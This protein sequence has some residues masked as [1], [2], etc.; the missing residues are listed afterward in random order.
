MRSLIAAGILMLSPVLAAASQAP[1][2]VQ[3]SSG[4]SCTALS[5][6]FLGNLKKG[7]FTAAT[8]HFDSKMQSAL[9]PQRLQQAWQESLPQ[10]F[11]AFKH[12]AAP[13]TT[14]QGAHTRVVTPLEF[15]DSW[16]SMIVSCNK[17]G[18]IEG[19]FFRPSSAPSRS[20][21]SAS[22]WI[23]AV[24]VGAKTL[25]ITVRRH[26]F[27]LKGVLDLP[28][29]KGPFPVID[30]IPGSGPVNLNGNDHAG[31]GG[32]ITYSPYKKLAAAVVK[33]GWAV[34]R[35]AKRGL[36]PSAG[37]GS[38]VVFANQVADNLA[39]VEALRKNPRVDPHRIVVAGHSIGGLVAL[40]LAVKTSVAGLILL[41]AP[42]ESMKKITTAQVL[43]M[44]AGASATQRTAIEKQQQGF[45]QEVAKA[46]PGKSLNYAGKHIPAWEVGLLKS[47]YKQN[48][49][50]IARRVSVPA[51]VVQGG[52]D[53][54]VPPGNGKR[55]VKALHH[56]ELLYLPKMGH[57]LD[58]A[59]CR[60]V[61]QLDT[62]KDATLVPGLAAGIIH[63][64]RATFQGPE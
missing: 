31:P 8:A 28:A 4:T 48:P 12:A 34:A 29:G 62:G 6:D 52:M 36:P 43:A 44:N 33:A 1:R 32:G 21:A 2:V 38:D 24:A 11:G 54:N 37:N 55:L 25:P 23:A 47:W 41:E 57:A 14:H 63:W 30:L 58:P 60:C 53:F 10:Q 3:S 16:L 49:I 39:V 27:A 45:Y 19:L 18:R 42:G 17:V 22:R 51:L 13:K 64:L 5:A 15:A 46:P 59:S 35:V 7:D 61:K 20:K 26:D 9:S 50:A 56:G 40:K